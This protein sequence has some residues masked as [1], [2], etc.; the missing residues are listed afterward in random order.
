M[1]LLFTY[2]L[3]DRG[4]VWNERMVAYSLIVQRHRRRVVFVVQML[5]AY[6]QKASSSFVLFRCFFFLA[7][8]IEEVMGKQGCCACVAI[9]IARHARLYV[10]RREST[11]EGKHI[12]SGS[13]SS[14]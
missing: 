11:A 6:F 14:R 7:Y 5:A 1:V 3:A 8:I 12:I 2:R 10:M 9:C 4:F 13:E